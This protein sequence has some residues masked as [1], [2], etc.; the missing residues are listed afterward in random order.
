MAKSVVTLYI[1]DASL[2]LVEADGK[3]IK[4]WA[5]LTLEPGLVKNSLVVNEEEVAARIKQL[6]KAHN[7]RAKKVIVGLSGLNCLT[8]PLFLPQLPSA[9]LHEAVIREARKALP[10]P[11]EQLYISWQA[12]PNP[13]EKTGVFLVAMP[14]K[15]ADALLRVLRQAGLVPYFMDIKP[16]ALARMVREPTAI[17]VDVQPTEF[18][19]VI[20]VDGIPQPIRTVPLPAKAPFGAE[21]LPLISK[22]L[23]RT[24]KFYEANNPE[25]PLDSSVPIY[26]SG[27]LAG[28]VELAQS[29]ANE[30]RRP[31]RQ[32]PLPVKCPEQ[33]DPR[34][35]MVN[36][37][38]ALKELPSGKEAGLA[39]AD[40]NVMPTTHRP[41]RPS[42][43]RIIA[44]PGAIAVI[45]LV[46]FQAM[47]VQGAS[48]NI[49][50]LRS[51]LD[52]T[53]QV[54]RQKQLQKQELMA[55]IAGLEENIA[56]AETSYAVFK[57]VLDKL[58][59]QRKVV[60]GDLAVTMVSLP[61]GVELTGISH[62]AGI[63][64]I[65]GQAVNETEALTYA[66][67]LEATL[68][69]SEVIIASMER[70]EGEGM[71]FTLMLIIKE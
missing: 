38:L 57:A 18:D 4:K 68:R 69:F 50:S 28:D 49:E 64:T 2:R 11:V 32:L 59:W 63:L 20:M 3:R 70:E 47:L 13:G 62:A 23:D 46:I 30:V 1:D 52:A 45:G 48:A 6:L 60:D 17:I 58:G 25:K 9:M 37:G 19:I 67:R 55:G 22:E 16:M 42:L 44:L 34:S 12:I 31:V 53:N 65:S 40:L 24:I 36:I 7:V 66:K 15:T 41:K 33:L 51:Q 56:Q 61:G 43:T 35:Y 29:L 10:V 54:L 71:D 39:V 14:V 27:G 21:K 8:R 5:D 26:V